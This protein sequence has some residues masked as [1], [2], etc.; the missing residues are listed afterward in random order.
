MPV[1]NDTFI[2]AAGRRLRSRQIGDINQDKPVL[3]FLHGAIDS[4]EMWRD[5]PAQ[6]HKE[7]GLA[8]IIYER[9]GHGQ[10]EPLATFREGDTRVE[11]AGEPLRDIFEHY[12]LNSVILVGHSY[13][14]VIALVAASLHKDV[15]LGVVSIVPQMI[16]HPQCLAG[17]NEAKEGFENGNLRDKLFKLHGE[18]LDTLFYD[19]I[20][21]VNSEAY[22]A[23]DCSQYLQQI[24]CPV[25]QIFGNEDAYGYLP[26]LDLSEKH[27]PS[28]LSINVIPDAGHYVHLEAKST[29]VDAVKEFCL[30]L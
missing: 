14:G 29:V 10:S 5:F 1:R 15:I 28:N 21:R 6:V 13:G 12:D 18:G 27:I 7:T 8:V 30:T 3:V 17:A 9:W 22:Q 20:K 16:I 26:N 25:L 23:E 24:T 19:W 11:E 4:I 2:Q